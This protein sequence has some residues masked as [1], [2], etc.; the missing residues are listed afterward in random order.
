MKIRL[1]EPEPPG[2][3]V[4]A[5]VLLPRLGLPIIAAT[6]KS[7]GHDVL[8]YNPTMAPIDW[9]DVY[10]SD[11]VGLSSTTSTASTAYGFADD[12]RSRGIP[13][14]IGGSHVTFMADEALQH[15]DYVA[16]GEGGEQ[17]MLEL[18]EALAGSRRLDD[19]GASPS[20]ATASPCTTRCATAAPTSTR[21]PSPTSRSSWAATGCR[22]CPS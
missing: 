8:V 2:M 11:V 22:P 16:R 17:L 4:W 9:E 1:I 18:I 21:Y 19:V 3:H 7:H 20:C 12:L 15:V 14:I 10:G 5:K 6:L 13:V